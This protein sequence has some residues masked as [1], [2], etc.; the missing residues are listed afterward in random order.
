MGSVPLPGSS[1]FNPRP[2][3][4]RRPSIS[5]FVMD[6]IS[7][8]PTSPVRETTRIRVHRLIRDLYFNPRPPCGRRRVPAARRRGNWLISTHVPRAGDDNSRPCLVP[9]RVYFNPRPPCG[10]RHG[11]GGNGYGSAAISTHVP[12]AGDDR[13]R[14]GRKS[15]FPDFNPRPPCGRRRIAIPGREVLQ[16]FQPTSPV[17]ETTCAMNISSR[18]RLF[19]PTSPVRETTVPYQVVPKAPADFNPRPPCGRRL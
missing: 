16:I 6:W 13:K 7:F 10:R 9:C 5:S 8:Q 14:N 19:Q 2:P 1:H 12:R 4:G 11:A 15:N 3:C 17:R 18:Q